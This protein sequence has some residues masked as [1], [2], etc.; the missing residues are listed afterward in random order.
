MFDFVRTQEDFLFWIPVH[1]TRPQRR[2]VFAALQHGIVSAATPTRRSGAWETWVP[3]V[4]TD[5]G[6]GGPCQVDLIY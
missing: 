5:Q 1:P 2:H 4:P 6:L 3:W